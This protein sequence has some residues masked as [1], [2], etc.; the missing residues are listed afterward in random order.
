MLTCPCRR[1]ACAGAFVEALR[2]ATN[3]GSAPGDERFKKQIAKMAGR[4][5]APLPKG[6][7]AADPKDKRQLNLLRPQFFY[8]DPNSSQNLNRR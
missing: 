2:A 7:P 1:L 5:V 6:Q 4:R 3:G 8:S